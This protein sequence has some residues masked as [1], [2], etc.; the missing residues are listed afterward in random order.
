MEENHFNLHRRF[1]V[2]AQEMEQNVVVIQGSE[3]GRTITGNSNSGSDHAWGGNYF[4]FGYDMPHYLN[5]SSPGID[6][7]HLIL[8]G[9]VRGGKILGDYPMSFKETDPTNIGRGR[10]I[11][12]RSWD[13]LFYGV[14]QWFGI[15]ETAELLYALPNSGNFGC[16]LFTDYDL[17]NSGTNT[18]EGC[19]GATQTTPV[20]FQVPEVRF[21][22]GEE[23]KQVCKLA[24]RTASKQFNVDI[25]KT[26]CYVADQ[27]IVHSEV[28][29]GMY[30]VNGIATLN[31]DYTIPTSATSQEEVDA[32]SKSASATASGELLDWWMKGWSLLLFQN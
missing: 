21:L 3:F 14:A 27:V 18:L 13:A 32:L 30:D 23:E 31:F 11:P 25:A 20:T 26:R 4:M 2:K 22:T 9:D 8:R 1:L 19:G 10:L 5:F 6:T 29:I 12:T 24:L 16:D 15:T 28:A 17:F 7:S